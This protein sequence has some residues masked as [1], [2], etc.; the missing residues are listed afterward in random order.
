MLP[1]TVFLC[2]LFGLYLL[3]IG[4]AMVTHAEA[5]VLKVGE[6]AHNTPVLLLWSTI[7]LAAGLAMVLA[8]NVWS[9]GVAAVLVTVLGW[10]ILIKA[11]LL[12]FLPTTV[13]MG[14]V[15]FFAFA[16]LIDVYAAVA[17]VVGAFLAF[18]GFRRSSSAART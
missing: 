3:L 14:F 12:L 4:L 5:T 9:G 16:H 8:H 11:L 15:G 18:A 13:M 1:R 2:R 10:I 6:L 17:I 7:A